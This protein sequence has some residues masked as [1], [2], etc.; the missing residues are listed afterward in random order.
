MQYEQALD[1]L[2]GLNRFGIRLGLERVRA[3]LSRMGDPQRRLRVLHVAGTN[4]KGSTCAM[5]DSILRT[6]GYRSG[7]YTS[8]Y[9]ER[10]TERIRLAGEEIPPSQVG[11]WAERVREAA[12]GLAESPT[13]FE[14]VTALAF[15]YY[16]WAEA[17]PVVL[18]VGL[19]GRHDATNVVE[20]PLVSVICSIGLDH[21][22]RLGDTLAAIAG[23]KA[24][25][26]KPGR[27]VLSAPAGP[28]VRRVLEAAAHSA[29]APLHFAAQELAWREAR[30]TDRGWQG[31]LRG[32]R[33]IYRGVTLPLLG[34][35]Q[36]ENAMLA[37]GAAELAM[38]E[39][40]PV[41][42]DAVRRG[43]AAVRWPG[44]LELFPGRPELVL[45]GAHNP[46]GAA[47]MAAA[48]RE[49]FPGRRVRLVLGVL[50][51]KDAPGI[52]DALAEA[53]PQLVCTRVPNPR[54]LPPEEL[55]A[56]ARAR[57][58]VT[59]VEPEPAAALERALAEADPEE[60]VVAAGSLYLVGALRAA[61]VRYGGE[62]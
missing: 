54:T 16:A 45:D 43:L 13:E 1:W 60:L 55:A 47:A 12:A 9:L 33:G 6:A 32:R 52:L 41:G 27:P 15:A 5:L 53:G 21:Q 46:A 18:E 59:V 25:I 38:E 26:I 28:E 8:P 39:G 17:D 14:A 19:G 3:M 11:R 57:G 37:V 44:R 61:A 34:R 20:S 48:L 31:T 50:A 40:L 58:F 51:D 22:D 42:E 56:L 49:H 29:G 35:H 7:L 30:P 4:G 23:E 24:G 10:F 36:L 62:A 2:E